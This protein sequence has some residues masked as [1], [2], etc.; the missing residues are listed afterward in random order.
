MQIAGI[1]Y[2]TSQL[3]NNFQKLLSIY[4]YSHHVPKAVVELLHRCNVCMSYAWTLKNMGK[5]AVEVRRAIVDAALNRP[6]MLSHDNIRLKFPIRSQRGNSQTVTDNGTA[7]TMF[8]LPESARAAF[9]DP[10]SFRALRSRLDSLNALGKA[11]SIS[12]SDLSNPDRRSRVFHHRLFHLFDILRSVPGLKS[13]DILADPLLQ[14]PD[15]WHTLPHGTEHRTKQYMLATKPIDES[16]YAGNLQVIDE[17]LRQLGLDRG[18]PLVKLTLERV[19]AWIG[20]DMTVHRCRGVKWFRGEER[21]GRD[22]LDSFIFIFGWFHAQLCLVSSIFECGRGSAAGIGFM[23]SVL[24]LTR[25]GFTED[26]RKKRPDYHTVVEFLMHEFEARVRGLWMWATGTSSL[27]DLIAWVK[28]PERSASDI[29]NLGQR[30]QAERISS[31]AVS[32]CRQQL[33][34]HEDEVF[35]GTLVTTRDLMIH[36]DLRYAVKHG[37]VGHME[38]VIPELLIYFTG[39]RNKN[40]ARQMYEILQLLYHETTPKIRLA[41]MTFPKFA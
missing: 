21:N 16:T 29:F 5:L 18:N 23:R 6:V 24:K 2:E 10:E 19:L 3:N 1:S 30:I 27:E 36:W 28:H 41:F 20:D 14:C 40:Y 32:V 33:D 31:Q 35:L 13:M 4:F 38:D 25:T 17:T 22:R 15:S 11:P 8:V 37:Q 12:W 34:D 39:G 9:E 7:I 26:M